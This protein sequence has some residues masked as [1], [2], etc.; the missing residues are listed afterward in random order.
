MRCC[1][2][3][4]SCMRPFANHATFLF[5]L[6]DGM[7]PRMLTFRLVASC[8]DMI[9]QEV[10]DEFK[11]GK[12]KILPQACSRTAGSVFEGAA[13]DILTQGEG[14]GEGGGRGSTAV[15]ENARAGECGGGRVHAA[16][17]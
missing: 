14:G 8:I 6:T 12:H 5:F 2:F 9:T 16:S 4:L 13:T 7:P 17:Q 15:K 1:T 11:K 10:A 3:A